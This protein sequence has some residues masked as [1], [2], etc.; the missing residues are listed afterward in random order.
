MRPV[1][2]KRL[3]Y[4]FWPEVVQLE[5]LFLLASEIP[6]TGV[7]LDAFHDRTAAETFYNHIHIL[8]CFDHGAALDG[9][10]PDLGFLDKRHPDFVAACEL[11]RLVA[12]VWRAKLMADFPNQP[13]RVYFTADD[14]P[15][16][17]F[18]RVWP[19]EPLWLDEARWATEI[20]AGRV[21]VLSTIAGPSND[22]A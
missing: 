6:K 19:E 14:D 16:V 9:S 2:E 8:D 3:M 15:V 22:A 4:V 1:D 17:R 11:G 5:G 21:A 10:D 7:D 13:F 12:S 18:H 20:A